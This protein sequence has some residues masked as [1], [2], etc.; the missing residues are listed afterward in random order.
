L[1]AQ[2][3]DGW[4]QFLDFGSAAQPDLPPDQRTAVGSDF[5]VN[6]GERLRASFAMKLGDQEVINAELNHLPQV[7]DPQIGGYLSGSFDFTFER[8]RAAQ[9]FP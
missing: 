8:G 4:I 5:K 3:V 7:P 1:T 2:V 9:V 6:F